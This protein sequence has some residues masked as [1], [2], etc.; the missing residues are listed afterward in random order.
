MINKINKSVMN[1]KVKFV[2]IFIKQQ[3]FIGLKPPSKEITY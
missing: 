1:L 3:K 2:N